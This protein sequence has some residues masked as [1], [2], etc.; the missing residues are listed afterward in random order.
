MAPYSCLIRFAAAAAG[1]FLCAPAAA[2]VQQAPVFSFAAGGSGLQLGGSD[3]APEIRVAP[4]DLPGV[5]RVANDLATDF[6]RVLGVNATVVVA[7][8]SATVSSSSSKPIILLGTIGH[9]SLI[10]TLTSSNKIDTAAVANK[11]ET[12]SYQVVSRPWDGRDAV[13]VIAGSDMRGTVF[14]AYDVSERIG[15]SPWH[16]WA[17]VP[18]TKREYIFASNDVHTEGPPSV[19]FRGIFLNDEA[20]GLTGWGGKNF[21]KSQYGSPF[22]TDFYKLIFELVLRLKGNYL[23]PAMWSSMFYLDDPNNGPTANEYGIFVGTSHHEPMARADKEQGRF[24]GGSWD[25]SSN[26]AGVQKFMEA[27]VPRSKDWS[28]IYTLGMRGSGDAASPTLT[29]SALQEVIQWQQS[30]LQRVLGKPLSEIP[31][32]WV[33]YKVCDAVLFLSSR[34]A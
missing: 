27:G 11:W 28:T 3:L 17:D 5:R 21:K 9:S 10:D 15:V 12:Y 7:D 8:W 20:P 33:M 1:L 19:K 26:K 30:T 24:L 2:Q 34:I 18:F 29:S 22:V 16:Y 32:A 31:Q 25:W 6:G 4:N 13:F 23:W 14:G